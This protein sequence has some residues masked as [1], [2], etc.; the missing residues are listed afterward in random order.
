MASLVYDSC[1]YDTS[2]GD[3]DWDNHS[4]KMM[5]VGTGYTPN[6]GTHTNRSHVTSEVSGTNYDAGGLAITFALA[7]D[8]TNHWTTITFN[9]LQYSN[10]TVS[11]IRAG[12]IY[13]T[14]GTANTD[15]LVAY[16]DFGSS[17]SPS[18][19]HFVASFTTPLKFANTT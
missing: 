10:L 19:Q 17:Y 15:L 4:F 16:V 18:A 14:T 8:T 2:K 1:I 13:K 11:G 9:S 3:I 6:K 12:V 7:N 5:L